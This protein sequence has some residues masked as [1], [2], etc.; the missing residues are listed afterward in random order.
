MCR[1]TLMIAAILGRTGRNG[2]V[3]CSK[4]I[5]LRRCSTLHRNQTWLSAATV[6]LDAA[7]FG[8]SALDFKGQPSALLCHTTGVRALRLLSELL[9]NTMAL[10]G[11]LVAP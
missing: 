5:P 3:I 2:F 7:S 10:S 1:R 11:G 4:R 8:L 9:G 6:I